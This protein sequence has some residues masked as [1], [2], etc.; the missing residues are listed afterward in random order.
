VSIVTIP[1][2]DDH[3]PKLRRGH[4]S[5]HTRPRFNNDGVK[6]RNSTPCVHDGCKGAF[7][8]KSLKTHIDKAANIADWKEQVKY[9][10]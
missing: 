1:R 5:R 9:S 7:D 3:F 4:G 8:E 6:V 2:F 10:R